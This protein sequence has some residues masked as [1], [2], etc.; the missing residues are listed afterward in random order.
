[1]VEYIKL[2]K[3]ESLLVLF[4]LFGLNVLAFLVVYDLSQ[5]QFL[6]VSFFDVGQGDSIF[7]ETPE[8]HQILIDGGPGSKVLEKLGKEMPFWDRSI[9]LV[10]LTHPEYDHIKGLIEVLKRYQIENILW[11]GVLKDTSQFEEWQKLIKA[12]G[13]REI[14]AQYGRQIVSGE[15]FLD[16]LNPFENLEGET[17]KNVN[18]TSVIIRLVFGE[19]SFLFTGDV[20]K[21]VEKEILE[22]GIEINSDVLKVSHH[23]SKT[24]TGEGFLEKVSPK[25]AVIQVGENTHGHPHPETLEVLEKYGIKTFRNDINGDIKIISN[26]TNLIIK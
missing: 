5:P 24:S 2:M 16:V 20:Y 25:I 13:A 9:D 3:K 1:M 26:G 4:L 11:T 18:N 17:I 6:E 14:I 15:I 22:K 7:I 21:A 19:N 12:E 8:G 10:I 23:G